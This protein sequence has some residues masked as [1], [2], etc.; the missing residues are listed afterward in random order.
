MPFNLG[1]LK[2]GSESF[3]EAKRAD[4]EVDLIISENFDVV[5]VFQR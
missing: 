5:V 4:A 2:K 1:L 3:K